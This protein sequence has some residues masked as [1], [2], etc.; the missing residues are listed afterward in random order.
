MEE[1]TLSKKHL[2]QLRQGEVLENL[3]RCAFPIS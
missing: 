3:L 1:S 2:E